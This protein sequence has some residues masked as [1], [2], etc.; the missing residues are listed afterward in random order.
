M[1]RVLVFAGALAVAALL[2]ATDGSAAQSQNVK[3]FG[4]VGPG[5]FITLKDQQGN[6]VTNL[7]PGTYDIEVKDLS[8]EHNFHLTGSGID[9]LTPVGAESTESWTVTLTDG[10]YRYFCDPHS[11]TMRGSFTVGAVQPPPSPPPP[12]TS[13]PPPV[14][15]KTKLVLTSGPGFVITLKTAK[16]KAVK[17]MKRGTYRM[18]VRDRGRTHNAHV[19]APGFNR[20]TRPLTYTGTQTWK[21]KLGKTG[22]LRFLC[23][24]HARRGMKGSAKIVR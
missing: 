21:V 9:R 14:T 12:T 3:L 20:K 8:E 5:F 19:I 16:G 18:V 10:T 15:A 2:G 7:D 24:P 6:R 13:T 17:R 4:T 23:D 11:T 1:P 22:T